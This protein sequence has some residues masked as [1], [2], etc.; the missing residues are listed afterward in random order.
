VRNSR[1]TIEAAV[2]NFLD[3]FVRTLDTEIGLTVGMQG[4]TPDA[5][6]QVLLNITVMP[7]SD[8]VLTDS[9]SCPMEILSHAINFTQLPSNPVV[10]GRADLAV[11]VDSPL[12]DLLVVFRANDEIVQNSTSSTYTFIASNFVPGYYNISAQLWNRNNETLATT[13]TTVQLYAQEILQLTTSGGIT[14]AL[15][16]ATQLEATHN[17]AHPLPEVH[18]TIASA[19]NPAQTFD[20]G[21]AAFQ[22]DG[23]ATL[24][25][26]DI[27]ARLHDLFPDI[28]ADSQ[29]KV[30]A[31]V[32]GVSPDDP[33]LASSNDVMISV[34]PP[35]EP[36]V[37][38]TE[39]P[40]VQAEVVAAPPQ[41]WTTLIAL[42]V[43][44]FL[45]NLFLL[46][47]ARQRRIQRLINNPDHH[48]LSP[49]LMTVTVHRGDT[50]RP[51]ALTKKTVFIGR[52]TSN[53][54]NLGDDPNISRQHGVIMW[55][56]RGWYYS[57]RKGNATVRING[58]RYRG[59]IMYK[60]EP[61][62]EIEIGAT[63]L[64]FHS[65]AQQDVSDFIKTNL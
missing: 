52:G 30:S 36:E 29:F 11:A 42:V 14:Q 9:I 20:L 27:Y 25:I 10:N 45:V 19:A 5:T 59:F 26:D 51:H 3:D 63:L 57:N 28:T 58:R 7:S 8:P 17:P 24:P 49:Q 4:K 15:E 54:I 12:K 48:D 16:G 2:S 1:A 53:D 60:L 22:P 44:F 41:N 34:K 47:W 65:S 46:R 40:A 38:P 18:F 35:G 32:P 64:L 21:P 23:K 56:R 13:P 50:R 33:N 37:V 43:V 55:R 39:I 6:G 62:T 31:F 61:V